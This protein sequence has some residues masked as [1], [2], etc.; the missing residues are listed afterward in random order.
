M[1]RFITH[2]GTYHADDV[3]STALLE[4]IT[5]FEAVDTSKPGYNPEVD[6]ESKIELLRVNKIEDVKLK[7]IDFVY[8]IGGGDFDH[9]QKDKKVRPNGIPYAAFGL[10]WAK[11]AEQELDLDPDMVQLMDEEFVQYI[12]QTDNF[13]QAK[14][15]NQLSALISANFQAGVPFLDTVHMIK[16]MLNNLIAQY[17]ELGEQKKTIEASFD[18]SRI[19]QDLN[20]HYDIRAFKNTNF[21]FVIG[22]SNRGD[23]VILRSLDSEKYPILDVEGITPIFIH[24]GRFTATYRNEEDAYSVASE[25]IRSKYVKYWHK[26][27]L[28]LYYS[29]ILL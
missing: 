20:N 25:S 26:F 1:I 4:L 5:G 3:L 12:D 13:G 19:F 7:L 9:H 22:P 29:F 15:P 10:L 16:P 23:G 28:N 17:K 14:Y 24:T 2:A 6:S 8:D 27:H 21:I 11:F 18:G